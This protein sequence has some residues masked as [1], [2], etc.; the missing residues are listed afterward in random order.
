MGRSLAAGRECVGH[1]LASSN[2][3]S[4]IGR[5]KR[6]KH[7]GPTCRIKIDLRDIPWAGDR[8]TAI[9]ALIQRPGVLEADVDPVTRK[10]VVIHDAHAEVSE[11]W[12]W[13][14]ECRTHGQGGR[15]DDASAP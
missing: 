10:A 6:S 8:E 1:P 13:L 4:A 9:A 5:N 14:V 15:G 7:H 12:N 11:L 2:K 3:R